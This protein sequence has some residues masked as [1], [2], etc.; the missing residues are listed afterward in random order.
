MERDSLE[1]EKWINGKHF[2]LLRRTREDAD[3]YCLMGRFFGSRVIAKELGMPLYDDEY[4]IWFLCLNADGQPVACCSLEQKPESRVAAFKSAWVAPEERG[5]GLYDWLFASR[6]HMAEQLGVQ[7]ITAITTEKS[8][9]THERY[10][11]RCVGMR[12]KYRIYWKEI[13]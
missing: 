8:R 3:F 6:L 4:R 13:L 10:G 1:E 2:R 7:K 12:G 11:F 5:Q 9:H